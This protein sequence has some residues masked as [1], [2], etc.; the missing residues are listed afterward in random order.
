MPNCAVAICQNYYK[1]TKGTDIKYFTFPKKEDLAKKW[2]IACRREDKIN[3]KNATICSIHFEEKYFEIP[4]KQR[5]LNYSPKNARN[6]KAEAV[7]T[8]NLPGGSLDTAQKQKSKERTLRTTKRRRRGEVED[9]IK[10]SA[11]TFNCILEAHNTETIT[12]ESELPTRVKQELSLTLQNY[13]RDHSELLKLRQ[14]VKILES[15]NKD[16]LKEI[17]GIKSTTYEKYNNIL[18]KVFT[19]GQ[20]K[21]LLNSKKNMRVCWSTEDIASAFSLWSVSPKA[22]RYL[23]AN[24]YPLPAQKLLKLN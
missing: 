10:S 3:L 18:A 8:L 13:Q 6:L 21:T 11:N 12:E 5:L 2:I 24:N 20:I 17:E 9:I 7:P 19:P 14:K 15:Q 1:S 4:L 22:Y 16:L 23:R